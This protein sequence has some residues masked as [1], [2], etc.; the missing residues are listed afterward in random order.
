MKKDGGCGISQNKNN[1]ISGIIAEGKKT[2][3]SLT[4]SK[5]RKAIVAVW[6]TK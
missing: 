3:T 5:K 2:L 4:P 6:L 1:L